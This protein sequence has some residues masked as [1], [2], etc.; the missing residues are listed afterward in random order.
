MRLGTD[1]R[2]RYQDLELTP[3]EAK[4]LENID[5]T[6]S[7]GQ[8]QSESPLPTER[9]LQILYT[10]VVSGIVE[11]VEG[12]EETPQSRVFRRTIFPR[13]SRTQAPRPPRPNRRRNQPRRRRSPRRKLRRPRP[14]TT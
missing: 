2:F 11:M 12:S 1:S 5:G 4:L 9:T 6:Q 3:T 10:L 13:N 7:F 14:K 8:I